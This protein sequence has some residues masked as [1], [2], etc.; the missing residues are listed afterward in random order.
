MLKTK[1]LYH[2]VLK[3]GEQFILDN[4]QRKYCLEG[5]KEYDDVVDR[6]MNELTENTN[7]KPEE[8]AYINS[9]MRDQRYI[10]G[11]GISFGLGNNEVKCSLS[12]CY[13]TPIKQDSIEGIFE[14]ALKLARTF[15]YRGG[16]GIDITILRPKNATVRNAAVYSSGA[17]SFAPLFSNVNGIIGQNGRRG[18]SI[19][20]LDVRHPDTFGM[21]WCKSKPEEIFGKDP[22]TGKVWDVFDANISI[23]LTNEFMEAV[24]NDDDWT[25]IF[26]DHEFDKYDDEWNGNYDEWIAKG[27]PIKEYQTVKAREILHQIAESA[28]LS[29]DPG[30][31]YWDN[32]LA[33]TPGS[34]DP[35]LT[36]K[37]CNPCGE[38]PLADF[39]N[40][41]L[42]A[43]VFYKYVLNPYGAD[44]KFNLPQFIN[45]VRHG[46]IF[47]D[48]L[49]DI[50]IEKH[51]LDEHKQIN[52]YGR[53]LGQEFTGLG[54]CLAMLGLEY[55]S[56]ESLQFLDYILYLKAIEELKTSLE[57][58]KEF[59]CAPCF[60]H[61]T[62]R[63]RY[64]E[65]PYID[66]LLSYVA[67]VSDEEL[68]EKIVDYDDYVVDKKQI[69]DE[70]IKFGL[71]NSAF[72][73]VGPTGTI[74]I[75]AGNCT[76]G[77][78]PL[79][80][81][82]YHREV[83]LQKE[84]NETEVTR[85]VHYPLLKH[86]GEEIL[87]MSNSEISRKY[88]YITAHDLDYKKRVKTQAVV[89]K[90]TDSSVSSTVNFKSDCTI[91]DIYD[92]Y[93]RGYEAGLKGITVFR[94]GSK[95]GVLTVTGEKSAED[96]YPIVDME[97]YL[98]NVKEKLQAPQ[99]SYRYIE[100]WKKVKVYL[101][102]SIDNH[103]RPVELFASV[104]YE[105][106]FKDVEG[107]DGNNNRYYDQTMFVERLVNWDTACRMISLSLRASVPIH[108]ICRQL[109]R[110]S[111][112]VTDLPAVLLRVLNNFNNTDEETVET[113]RTTGDGG[114]YCPSCKKN[115]LIY[116]GGCKQCQLCGDTT[117]G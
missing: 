11:G 19:I 59:G 6:H 112:S 37:G 27:Y 26:P 43:Q 97:S 84:G 38:Q 41:F 85:I 57:R 94:D 92:V 106:G 87:T 4:I 28:W 52:E 74:S 79:F 33:M 51:P 39:D 86:I 78:E 54:D 88:N 32:V 16:S 89:Q 67:T 55:G 2:T 25:F 81:I 71:R 68:Q 44:A 76:S 50:S 24:K 110:A 80:N 23:K 114:E 115:G 83:R 72:N 10:T 99:R 101:S 21:I 107:L 95:K 104:P 22:L 91:E 53:R 93:I 64:V 100:Y 103:G 90:W 65:H 17:V 42:S 75:V 20:L 109:Q 14:A 7:L 12:N 45:D 30:V 13:F 117:C 56:E 18:A 1:E 105:A 34:F 108:H 77:I 36:P 8:I 60:K 63:K 29:G 9:M 98:N 111:K 61:K 15:S 69:T 49:L 62:Q 40:C 116:T 82:D 102:V 96:N 47:L 46:I 58:S 70:I 48:G 5:E 31:S 66:R 73:T 3:D 35:K 113:I